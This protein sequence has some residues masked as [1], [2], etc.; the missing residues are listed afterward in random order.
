MSGTSV[1]GVT[2]AELMAVV[3]P[4]VGLPTITQN[5]L[6][7]LSKSLFTWTIPPLAARMKFIVTKIAGSRNPTEVLA[8]RLKWNK[9]SY[10]GGDRRSWRLTSLLRKRAYVAAHT[11]SDTWFKVLRFGV[12]A[13]IPVEMSDVTDIRTK[14]WRWQSVNCAPW[15]VYSSKYRSKKINGLLCRCGRCVLSGTLSVNCL[16]CYNGTI[17]FVVKM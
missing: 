4:V 5:R 8:F 1:S 3:F 14:R 9:K 7:F 15:I 6:R 2:T 11:S 16:F 17:K 12:V 10:R 13:I